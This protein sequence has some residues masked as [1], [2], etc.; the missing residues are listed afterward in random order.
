MKLAKPYLFLFIGVISMFI[1]CKKKEPV[2]KEVKFSSTHYES[3]G[4]FSSDGKPDYL[5]TPDPYSATLMTFIDSTLPQG[6]DLRVSHPELFTTNAIADI[7]ITQTSN[8]FIT[9]A[10]Q[11]AG[12]R[13][14]FAYYKYP[15]GKSPQSAKDIDVITY[16]FPSC[17]NGTPLK[18]GDKVDLGKFEAGTSIGFVLMQNAWDTTSRKD[19]NDAVHF[20][21]N[22]ILNPEVD[23]NLKKHAVMINAPDDRVL[24]GFEDLN[25]TLPQCDHDFNDLVVY[26]TV[27]KQ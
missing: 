13:N 2:T 27:V 16:I 21:S 19:N 6:K 11:G 7:Q 5:F 15:T 14:A 25:R 22:D 4:S 8:V 18:A 9:F 17:G 12:W 26:C 24:I 10:L 23:P 20:C 1:S 3:L